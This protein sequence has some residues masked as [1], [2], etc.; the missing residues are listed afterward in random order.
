MEDSGSFEGGKILQTKHPS[1]G[2]RYPVTE[3]CGGGRRGAVKRRSVEQTRFL[4]PIHI[5]T[6]GLD[7]FSPRISDPERCTK[8]EFMTTRQ[9]SILYIVPSSPWLYSFSTLKKLKLKIPSTL[10][11]KQKHTT[12]RLC[13][14]LVSMRFNLRP[15]YTPPQNATQRTL[16]KQTLITAC[17]TAWSSQTEPP[18]HVSQA[19]SRLG[20]EIRRLI[21]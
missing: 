14:P 16:S 12:T 17:H 6:I 19:N 4:L 10:R 8:R 3:R 21:R 7:E 9:H 5:H 13:L 11:P 20:S 15:L 1:R 18:Q 2:M